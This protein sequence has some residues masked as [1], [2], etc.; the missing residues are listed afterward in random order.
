MTD[1]SGHLTSWIYILEHI[2][3]TLKLPTISQEP[4]QFY[5]LPEKHPRCSETPKDLLVMPSLIQ[6]LTQ[7]KTR[8]QK[9][10]AIEK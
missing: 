10:I 1:C 9:G 8:T 7:L 5:T 6:M 2:P 3:E 4:L